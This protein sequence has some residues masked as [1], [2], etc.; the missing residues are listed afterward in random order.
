MNIEHFIAKRI[1]FT[2]TKSFT[3]VIIRIA[4]AAISVSLTVMI[5][6]SA[7]IAGFKKEISQKIFGFWGHIH[8]TDSNINRNFELYPINKNETFYQDIR[9]IKQLDYVSKANIAGIELDDKVQDKTTFGG[10]KGVHPYIM[11]PG[12]LSTKEHFHGMLLKGV[13]EEYDWHKMEAFITDGKKITYLQDSV[14]SDLLLS[15]NIATKLQISV[16]DKVVL[17][18]IRENEQIKKRFQVCG[19]YNTGL[20][21]YDKRFGLVDIGKLQDILHWQTNEVQGMEVVLEDVRDLDVY[22]EYIYYEILPQEF[23][24]ESIRS[25][26]PGIFEWLKLQDINE[27]IILQLMVLVAIINMIT[28]LL[29]LILER[30]QMIGILKSLGMNNW[31]VRKIFMYHAGYIILFGLI[32]GNVLGLG[33][34]FLQQK[35]S[36][37]S[38]DE[39]NYYLSTAPIDINWTNILLLNIGTLVV[40]LVFLIL[41]T[42]LVT[43]ITPIKALRF[44]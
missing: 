23:Y 17:S 40:T 32:I 20:E 30:T 22:A 9:E 44:E 13:D 7:I 2:N 24:A 31:R 1:A 14:S 16:G 42:M 15:K 41:P 37:I 21:E 43:R 25:K 33:I 10:V 36:F 3:K 27:T 8:I 29:I 4:I 38:L 34:A 18:F 35:Y 39:A 12:L 5:L 6:T 19:I 26:F 11:M 28:V